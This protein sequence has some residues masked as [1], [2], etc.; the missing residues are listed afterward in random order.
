MRSISA[1]LPHRY[2]FFL[3]FPGNIIL[4]YG[5]SYESIK[6][7]RRSYFVDRI[8]NYHQQ[9]LKCNPFRKK[10]A[11]IKKLKRMRYL[12]YLLLFSVC[13]ACLLIAGCSQPGQSGIQIQ[14]SKQTEQVTPSPTVQQTSEQQKYVVAVTVQK[15]GNNIVITYQGGLDTDKLLYSTIS[16]N[17]IEQSKKLG[18]TPGETITLEGV[19]TTS[20][21]RVIVVGHFNDGSTQTILDSGK[22]GTGTGPLP[23]R[24]PTSWHTPPYTYYPTQPLPTFRQY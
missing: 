16:V 18:N 14:P 23:Y 21:D 5:N 4:P 7:P 6:K 8:D 15:A 22:P 10:Y 17:G 12:S 11:E 3:S 9:I 13:I 20:N 2:I 19:A 24:S 1:V